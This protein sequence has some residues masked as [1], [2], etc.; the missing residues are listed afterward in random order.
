MESAL[1]IDLDYQ[2]SLSA[3]LLQASGQDVEGIGASLADTALSGTVDAKWLLSAARSLHPLFHKTRLITSNYSL[4]KTENHLM[5]QWLLQETKNDPRF[6]L[7]DLLTSDEIQ[8]N[9]D[10]IL[11]DTPPR[12][13]TGSIAALA[14]SHHYVIP[15]IPNTLSV[16]TMRSTLSSTSILI[17]EL[18]PQLRFSGVIASLTFGKTIT[19]SENN[20]LSLVEEAIDAF[21]LPK[22]IFQRN[23]PRMNAIANDAGSK[24]AYLDDGTVRALFD[25]LGDQ[26]S[27]R[28]KL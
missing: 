20:A 10:I 13:T 9:F 4:S 14:T 17:R 21:E 25:E 15:T 28:I 5:L 19:Q 11:I 22:H 27:A 18:N 2:G 16:E 26:I 23:I 3:M 7:H 6:N 24:V 12:L 8:S 1:V